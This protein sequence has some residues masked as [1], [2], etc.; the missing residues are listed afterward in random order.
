MSEHVS[1]V[2][3]TP[4]DVLLIR[5]E[6]DLWEALSRQLESPLPVQIRID[7]WQPELLYFPDEPV[8]HSIS[9]RTIR[10]L[11]S[12]SQDFARAYAVVVY[13]IPSAQRLN[14]EDK[15]AID[16]VFLAKSG[17]TGY[18]TISESIDRFIQSTVAKMSPKQTFASVITLL[19]L[20]FGTTAF[21]HW[22]SERTSERK[23][24][25]EQEARKALSEEETKRQQLLTEVLNRSIAALEI[26]QQADHSKEALARAAAPR[27]KARILGV[28]LT[29]KE[30]ADLIASEQP[31][32]EGKRLDGTFKVHGITEN[33][34]DGFVAEIESVAT[35]ET[36]RAEMNRLELTQE[37]IDNMFSALRNGMPLP[38]L[39]NV[40][41]IGEKVTRAFVMRANSPS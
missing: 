37:D 21:N 27:Q 32:A 28:P 10:S 15:Q 14:K 25:M 20:F 24:E 4:S 31:R 7:G 33:G 34:E 18:D 22:I 30:A 26:K 3:N 23:D 1:D 29:G 40:R 16:L 39:V 5:S 2:D 35:G 8:S 13:G 6:G 17:S 38:L 11:N 36:M 12:F 9:V 41:F 19:L